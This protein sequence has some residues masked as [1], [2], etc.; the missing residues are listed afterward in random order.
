MIVV[1]LSVQVIA[2]D[3]HV[4]LVFLGER[5]GF[6]ECVA[7]LVCLGEEDLILRGVLVEELDA[8]D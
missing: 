4:V 1:V 6:L 8:E 5:D 2:N 7:E 3:A